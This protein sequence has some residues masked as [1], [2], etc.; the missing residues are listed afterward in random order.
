MATSRTGYR[1]NAFPLSQDVRIEG[2]ARGSSQCVGIRVADVVDALKCR[3]EAGVRLSRRRDQLAAL[4][5]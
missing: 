3:C 2:R 5:Q 1:E 4:T